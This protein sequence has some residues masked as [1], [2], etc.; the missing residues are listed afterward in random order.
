M[1][2]SKYALLRNAKELNELQKDKLKEIEKVIPELA[3][4]HQM[5]ESFR[6]IFESRIDWSEALFQLCDWLI[7]S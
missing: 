3:L 1:I 6:D 2:H 5:K 7:D 4:M